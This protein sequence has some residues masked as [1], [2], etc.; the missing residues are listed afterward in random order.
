MGRTPKSTWN[1]K[2]KMGWNDSERAWGGSE[3]KAKGKSNA[4][5][6]SR[7]RERERGTARS[8]PHHNSCC[9]PQIHLT[10][11]KQANWPT[12]NRAQQDQSD[13]ATPPKR[14][15]EEDRGD[16]P[17]SAE[18]QD[19][20]QPRCRRRVDTTSDGVPAA[21][22]CANPVATASDHA[23]DRESKEDES[24]KEEKEGDVHGLARGEKT[25]RPGKQGSGGL[26]EG[27]GE[28]ESDT[29]G[30]SSGDG[31]GSSEGGEDEEGRRR[32]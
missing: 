4:E 10:E 28:K 12:M 29:D 3:G 22:C 21:E 17:N 9:C 25:T 31:E 23:I 20:E 1:R 19:L 13:A 15:R 16:A 27:C 18:G 14:K 24:L 30:E 11:Q 6:A 26:P 5:P 8:R 2:A 7:Q 32:R